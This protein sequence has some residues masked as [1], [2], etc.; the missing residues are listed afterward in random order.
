VVAERRLLEEA[1]PPLLV[2]L[3]MGLVAVIC[4]GQER[5]LVAETFLARELELIWEI[6]LGQV[7]LSLRI[8][9]LYQQH[10]FLETCSALSV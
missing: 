4:S 1:K 2:V 3:A 5:D 8:Q 6:C 10:D 9:V 7:E